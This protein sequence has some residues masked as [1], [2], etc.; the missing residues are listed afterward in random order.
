MSDKNLLSSFDP[1]GE[2]FAFVTG[3][4]RLKVCLIVFFHVFFQAIFLSG[5]TPFVEIAFE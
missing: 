4:N 3:D 1:S 5:Q 2:W